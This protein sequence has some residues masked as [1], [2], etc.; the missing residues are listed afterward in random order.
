M[1]GFLVIDKPVG[2]S[3]HHVVAILRAV[4]GKP[5]IGHTGTLDPFA[6][7]VLVLAVGT[8]TRLISFLPEEQKRYVATL[9]LGEQSETGDTEGKIICEKP[10][11]KHSEE[12]LKRV[13][14]SMEGAQEQVPPQFSA[15]KHKGK[16]LYTYAR[17]GQVI[18]LKP[19]PIHIYSLG[20]LQNTEQEI[21]F[22]SVV[23]RG[24]YIRKLGE[25]IAEKI[26]TVGHLVALRREQSGI[27]SRAHAIQLETISQLTTGH[28][29]WKETLSLEGKKRF[30]RCPPQELWKKLQPD[31][32]SVEDVFASSLAVEV[33]LA[34][35]NKIKNGLPPQTIPS[36]PANTEFWFAHQKKYIAL[37][38]HDDVKIKLL[39]VLN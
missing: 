5:K 33:S 13:L 32:L 2:I 16:P 35:A 24:T 15:V 38:R 4:L 34:R 11:P 39:R 36:V 26:G 31:I 20:L 25:D 19:R 8:Y 17:K 14:A 7:G 27:F 29:N 22:S 37:A 6:S 30:A 18:A 21:L 9:R 23:S 10:V 3:S 1:R 28:T 12:E